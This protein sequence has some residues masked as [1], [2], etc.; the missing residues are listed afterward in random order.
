MVAHVTAQCHARGLLGA[1]QQATV[2]GVAI[3]VIVP[4]EMLAQTSL[5]PQPT[6]A[7]IALHLLYGTI[8]M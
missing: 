6:A 5:V 1:A 2:L 8:R 7:Q 3:A 4:G